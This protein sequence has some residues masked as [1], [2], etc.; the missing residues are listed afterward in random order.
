MPRGVMATSLWCCDIGVAGDEAGQ[1]V[2]IVADQ[3]AAG[4]R[5]RGELEVE[6]RS[7]TDQRF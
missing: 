6:Q 2:V 3:V 4:L 5:R 7:R 1:R